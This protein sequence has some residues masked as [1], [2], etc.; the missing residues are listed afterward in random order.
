MTQNH[1]KVALA[2]TLLLIA[3]SPLGLVSAGENLA[4]VRPA[5]VFQYQTIKSEIETNDQAKHKEEH[6]HGHGHNH[7]E[8][9]GTGN[10]QPYTWTVTKSDNWVQYDKHLMTEIWLKD[11]H[12]K[13][14]LF[15]VLR[16]EKTAIEYSSGDLASLSHAISWESVR[17]IL[18]PELYQGI[19]DD[20]TKTG[21]TSYLSRKATTHKVNQDDREILITWLVEEQMPAEIVIENAKTQQRIET[22][23]LKLDS[24]EVHGINQWLSERQIETFDYADVGDNESNQTLKKLINMG[25]IAPDAHDH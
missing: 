16:P 14:G 20:S 1:L 4:G 12:N 3:V 24:A 6:N 5:Q 11:S 25:S 18:P 23:L 8:Q 9:S 22:K 15:A 13:I 10:N 19:K 2:K 21:E 7:H 17:T